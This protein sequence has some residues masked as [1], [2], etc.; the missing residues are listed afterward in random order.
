MALN[1]NEWGVA[2]ILGTGFNM[3][4]FTALT[5][6]FTLP[7]K[8]TLIKTNPSVGISNGVNYGF[9]ANTYAVYTFV[10]GDLSVPGVWGARLSYLDSGQFLTSTPVS[11]VVNP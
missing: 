6:T 5:L 7:N 8:T 11:F 10:P 2:F 3:S 4:G 9:P 1:L